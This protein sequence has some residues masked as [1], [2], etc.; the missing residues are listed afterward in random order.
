MKRHNIILTIC[1]LAGSLLASNINA[2]EGL[3]AAFGNKNNI[4][5]SDG[6][7]IAFTPADMKSFVESIPAQ[8]VKAL[9]D[10]TY[11]FDV[12]YKEITFPTLMH[13]NE[14][15]SIV[16]ASFNLAPIPDTASPDEYSPILLKLL[17]SNGEY[18]DYFFSYSEDTRMITLHGCIQVRGKITNDDLTSHL[19]N[20]GD[21]AIEKQNLW[22]PSLWNHD[23]PR[24]IGSWHSNTHK[25]D[26]VLSTS[27]R[28]ELNTG[29]NPMKG[30]YA[31][32]GDKLTMQDEK[33]ETIQGEV[34]FDNANQFSILVNGNEIVFV[35]M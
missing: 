29:G 20:M 10:S 22:N 7:S 28:F 18:G 11:R 31:I 17:S 21:V 2:N 6:S 9:A 33:G 12:E 8:N 34:R 26:L 30:N 14:K 16:W 1:F 15:G 13:A 23:N 5:P 32:D 3:T 24:H 19:I 4:A 25:M 35:R 27:N